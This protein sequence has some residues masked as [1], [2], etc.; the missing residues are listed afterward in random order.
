[1]VVSLQFRH[2]RLMQSTWIDFCSFRNQCH[3][4]QHG[5][6]NAIWT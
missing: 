4:L 5:D 2:A 3:Y 1:V 6:F